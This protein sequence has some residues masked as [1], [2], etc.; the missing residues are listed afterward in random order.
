MTNSGIDVPLLARLIPLVSRRVED[1]VTEALG[2]LLADESTVRQRMAN[3]CAT[4]LDKEEMEI[5]RFRT[6]YGISEEAE[7]GGRPDLVGLCGSVP[8]LLLEIKFWAGLTDQQ[9]LGYLRHVMARGGAGVVFVVPE[10]RVGEVA[11]SLETRLRTSGFRIEGERRVE[12]GARRWRAVNAEGAAAWVAVVSWARL[13][14]EVLSGGGATGE[15]RALCEYVLSEQGER[16]L[17]PADLEASVG[18]SVMK[19]ARVVMAV[20]RELSHRGYALYGHGSNINPEN[21]RDP[22]YVGT[23]IRL[24]ESGVEQLGFHLWFPLW[25]ETGIPFWLLADEHTRC[26]GVAPS[27]LQDLLEE[28]WSRGESVR[29]LRG[30][31]LPVPV[32]R[33]GDIADVASRIV[34]RIVELDGEL[35]RR[36]RR[37]RQS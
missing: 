12:R 10:T 1:A 11:A 31:F 22:G 2:M 35:A 27:E 7:G 4:L 21:P 3:F 29:R 23:R 37:A 33:T 36:L 6:Q 19:L 30:C 5:E 20:E 26:Q 18:R 16:T 17:D 28:S 14:A 15:V 34:E 24:S 8:V 9:P 13:I 32:E 25:V